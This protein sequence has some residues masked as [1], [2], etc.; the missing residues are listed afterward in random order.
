MCRFVGAV[1]RKQLFVQIYAYF[2]YVHFVLNLGVASY[3]LYTLVHVS[4][5]DQNKACQLAIQ[6]TT[7]QGQCTGL[8]KVIRS[9]R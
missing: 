6:D 8:L 2:I 4:T 7:A 5:I 1:V 3:L 9:T